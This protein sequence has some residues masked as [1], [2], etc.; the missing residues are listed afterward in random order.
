[1][2]PI[3]RSSAARS[4]GALAPVSSRVRAMAP[5]ALHRPGQ[6]DVGQR[7]AGQRHAGDRG[8][9]AVR[10]VERPLA[11]F[12]DRRSG[13]RV[14][15]HRPFGAPARWLAYLDGAESR[16]RSHGV[17]PA[18]GRSELEDGLAS[19][20]L[21]VAVDPDD[22]VIAGIRCH[23]PLRTAAEAHA[24]R[25][26]AGHPRLD[27]VEALIAE[28]LPRGLVEVKG[29]WVDAD[30][31]FPG[32]S[33]ALARCHVH[34]MRWF[35]AQYAMCTCADNVAPRW[36]STG[37]RATPDLASVAY[38]DD[39]YR[40]LLLWWDRDRLPELAL[41]DQWS[42][43]VAEGDELEGATPPRSAD[44]PVG[45]EAPG[46]EWRAEVL[47]RRIPEDAARLDRL[48]AEPGVVVV[49]RLAEQLRGLAAV[50][51]PV[52]ADHR[53]EGD[54]WV[55]YPWRR[56]VVRVLGPVSFRALR[57]DRNRNK[58]TPEEQDRLLRQRI[59]VV[60]LSVGHS[61]AYVLALEGLCGSLRLADFDTI[62]LSNLNRI[63]ATVLD[64]GVNKAVVVARRIAELDPYVE[65]EVVPEG[66][67]AG[68]V[69]RFLTDLDVVA[70]ECDSLDL[71][72]LVRESARRAR[73]PVVMETSDRGLFDVERFDLEPDRPLFH[74]LLGD[75]RSGQLAGLSTH[76]K[77]PHVLRLLEPDQLSSRMAASMAEIDETVTTWPQLGSDVSLGAAT[78]AAAV[79][80]IGRGQ[81]L[82]SGRVRVDLEST[83]DGVTAP[84]VQVGGTDP[85]PTMPAPPSDAGLAI[86][87]AANLAPS[88]GN[89]QPWALQ[90]DGGAIRVLLDRSRTSAMDVQ[91]RGSYV[92]I[93][94]ALLNARVA[95]SALGVLGALRSFPEGE[96][97]DLVG[98][99]E[100]GSGT[101][102]GL[103]ALYPGVLHRCTNR[104]AGTPGPIDREVVAELHRQVRCEGATLHLLTSTG[105]LADYAEALG[106]SDRLR[107][108]SPRLHAELMGELRW[109]GDDHLV[110]GIDVRTLELDDADLA[111]LAVA[112]RADV[113]ADLAAWDG[114]R[115]LGTVTRDRVR[116]SSALAVVTVPGTR[117]LSYVEG[118][119]AVQ[120]LW[121]AA[122]AAGLAVQP[123]SPLSVFATEP[124][125]FA[126]LVPEPYVARLQGVAARLRVIAGLGEGEAIALV[127]R[128][129][130]T[131]PP[132]A[133]SLRIPLDVALLGPG[134]VVSGGDRMSGHEAAQVSPP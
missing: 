79:R 63:P 109:L 68:N 23:G 45:T 105:D 35:G 117:P 86:A 3:H 122:D 83:L 47:D 134:P 59:G 55:H 114:G 22:C 92:A 74:G 66:L 32:L 24:L 19:S 90:L 87:H 120:R 56:T 20:L 93:G 53:A 49:D 26:L 7:D 57:L 113:M 9:P 111:K 31:P 72:L 61:I 18:L 36:A 12:T 99:L 48:R 11:C 25:E 116:S 76:D 60:G 10:S 125:D 5:G 15:V 96:G 132:S 62:E 27:A 94:A 80:R 97:S 78:V 128:L 115:A 102:A 33:D 67:T 8:A 50:R 119:A 64:L 43:L 77:V 39:R 71:K 91:H 123:V 30:A 108:L 70:E 98:K 28:R 29:A 124:R 41:P 133:R 73:I 46:E 110:T 101:D 75:V 6:L 131:G 126:S 65:L 85:A 129:S 17:L 54:R 84:A 103:A 130:H 121:L 69:D 13:V 88:G 95:A 82:P 4:D 2:T 118:G 58:I 34:A 44:E 127:L 1:M 106:E 107:Y 51:A 100:L 42:R 37:G 52:P 38:P 112:R 14:E 89:S 40:T 81:D 104:R 21:F 16:Y